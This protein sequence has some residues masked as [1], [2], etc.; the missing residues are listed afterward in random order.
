MYDATDG[1][2]EEVRTLYATINTEFNRRSMTV[3]GATIGTLLGKYL[4]SYEEQ[5][6]EKELAEVVGL[7]TLIIDAADA[8]RRTKQ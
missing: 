1:M 3:V 4:A 8:K 2:L 7:A 5:A 6:R